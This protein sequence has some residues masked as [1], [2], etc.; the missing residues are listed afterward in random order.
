MDRYKLLIVD[1]EELEREGMAKFI[2]WE[3]YGIELVDTAWN[4]VEGLEKIRKYHPDI[5][6]TDIMMPGMNGIELIRQAKKEFPEIE[7]VVLS[8]YGEYEYTS[9]AMEE[10]VRHYILKPCDEEKILKIIDKVKISIKER[11]EKKEQI[12]QYSNTIRDALPRAKEQVFYNLLMGR[13]QIQTDYQLFMEELDADAAICVLAIRLEKEFDYIM[14]FALYNILEELLDKDVLLL[15]T[16]F[17]NEMVFLLRYE[18]IGKINSAVRRMRTELERFAGKTVYAALSS[19]G[20]LKDIRALYY[21]TG[22]LFCMG[23]AGGQEAL[24]TYELFRE[25]KEEFDTLI[26]Y[27]E[28][29]TAEDTESILSELY[30]V[31]CKMKIK[32]YSEKKK[33]QIYQWIWK[34]FDKGTMR[35]SFMDDNGKE[36]NWNKKSEW[37]MLR[38]T[39][40]FIAEQNMQGE[41]KDQEEMR[42]E[43]ILFA[44]FEHLTKPELSIRY[45]AREV[46]FM[47][48]DYFGRLFQRY[49]KEKFSAYVLKIRIDLAEKIMRYSPDIK[50]SGRWTIFFQG[51]P[52]GDRND[53]VTVSGVRK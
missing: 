5:V 28:L 13:E 40:K 12:A 30:L 42:M 27:T 33:K 46:L 32:G 26:N 7:F 51:I 11:Y 53:A 49:Q 22:E 16:A 2:P 41:E 9:Q 4:G 25:S 35:N 37:E 31:S 24:L 14:Q 18:N 10:G 36:E 50:V 39:A 20:S 52:Q 15:A 44:V 3:D 8:G 23:G 48:E 34:V 6:L 47:N 1:D 19:A 38:D 43:R 45:L 29:G 21:Q 17:S